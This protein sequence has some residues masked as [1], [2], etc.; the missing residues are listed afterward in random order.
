MDAAEVAL[1]ETVVVHQ[2]PV[3]PAVPGGPYWLPSREEWARTRS[4]RRLQDGVHLL[5]LPS[6]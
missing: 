6:V 5:P 1:Q 4:S 2:F 3:E